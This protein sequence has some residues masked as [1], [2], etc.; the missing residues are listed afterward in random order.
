M[1]RPS[2]ITYFALT[3]VS[4]LYGINYSILKI[5]VPAYVGPFGFIVYR[6]AISAIIFWGI[7]A[8]IQEKINWKQDGWRLVVC[9]LTGI[10]VNQL[11]FFKGVSL[12]TA[13]NGS[14]IMTLTPIMVLIWAA[15][16]IN[17]R[18]TP[19]KILGILLGLVG[20]LIIISKS[21]GAES[22]GNWQ[23]DL[24]VFINAI[25]YACYLVLV[26]PLMAHYR[27]LTVIT[28]VFTFGLVFV[29]PVGWREALAVFPV[30]FPP[31]VWWSAVYTIL[32]V[33]VV[34]YALNAW[35]LKK[36]NAS[37]VGSFIYLQPIFATLTAVLFFDEIFL[38]EHI[39]A[40]VFVFSGV[41]LVTKPSLSVSTSKD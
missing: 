40:S 12:T 3:L 23:G 36:V 24:L 15:I 38:W 18:I 41:W 9:G 10:A 14:I 7:H 17:E 28:W 11:L 25:S 20:A 4:L 5:V 19:G 32:G 33:T 29:I 8:F 1:K 22:S 26:K 27:P 34:V 30:S 16:L 39:L 21:G 37:V 13:V 31:Q 35:T 2:A 6:V